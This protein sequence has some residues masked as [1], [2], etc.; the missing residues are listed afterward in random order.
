MVALRLR[1]GSS[2][3]PSKL[4]ALAKAKAKPV[5]VTAVEAEH[6]EPESKPVL[7][8]ALPSLF[9]STTC[10]VLENHANHSFAFEVPLPKKAFDKPSPD[11]AV[12]A[13]ATARRKATAIT[14]KPVEETTQALQKI[15]L[16]DV[17]KQRRKANMV[18]IGH[19]DAGKSTLMGRLL[20]DLKAVDERTLQ[21][22]RKESEKIGR[23]SFALAW[24]LDESEE[25]R[26]RGVTMDIA[27]RTFSTEKCD[28]TILDAPGHADFI[29]NMI[30][31]VA[32]ADFGLLVIDASVGE[33]ES[34]LVGQTREHALLS[35]ALGISYLVVAV[36]KLDR[37]DWSQDRIDEIRIQLGG[38]LQQAGYSSSHVVYVSCS[39]L[40]GENV[41]HRREG[42]TLIEA[43]DSVPASTRPIDKPLRVAVT[44]VDKQVRG[45]VLAGIIQSGDEVDLRG[46]RSKVCMSGWAAAGDAVSLTCDLDI[47]A[48]DVLSDPSS[49]VPV[50]RS[51]TG[52]IITFPS[53]RP[54][55]IGA[56]VTYH[57]GRTAVSAHITHI[58]AII[59]KATGE[60]VRKSPR[61][62]P[63]SAA[64]LVTI[65]IE[66]LS[67]EPFA[68]NKDIGRFALRREGETIAAGIVV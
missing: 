67:I 1:G 39:G 8:I 64:A 42:M 30:A 27:T 25:E 5:H 59:D 32:L 68:I 45:T 44:D 43:L 20:Y 65:G 66:P 10:H 47:V 53:R 36:N 52:R 4:A 37:V 35:R 23:G 38:F 54:L 22:Y 9:A 41:V 57:R 18:I 49:P 16:D 13:A 63:S 51:F 46:T 31:G 48:G 24:V 58:S 55:H 26:K 33:F 56:Q 62:I 50:V 2:Q 60:V 34:G 17:K 15:T 21:R 29:P 3:K 11:D 28:Y 19:V 61:V 12:A 40:S 14:A 7:L 6:Y